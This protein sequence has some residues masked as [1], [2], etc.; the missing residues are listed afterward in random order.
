MDSTDDIQLLADLDERVDSLI[1]F[2]QG[3]SSRQL[4]PNP[5][6][7]LRDHWVAEPDHID[8]EFEK[9][10]CHAGGQCGVTQQD[11]RD[12]MFRRPENVEP[13]VL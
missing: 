4:D 11:R 8:A 10:V 2:F 12:C 7:V 5:G 6:G 1:D 9:V 3:M 13:G